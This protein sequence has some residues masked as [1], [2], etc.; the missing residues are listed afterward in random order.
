MT[1]QE[2]LS[3]TTPYLAKVFRN[4]SSFPVVGLELLFRGEF[5][6]VGILGNL[7]PFS[8][9]VTVSI[10]KKIYGLF[11]KCNTKPIKEFLHTNEL[12]QQTIYP[13]YDVNNFF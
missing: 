2:L 13:I 10:R 4:S 6:C 1:E 12:F 3:F 5:W 8:A 7:E 9:E 11:F